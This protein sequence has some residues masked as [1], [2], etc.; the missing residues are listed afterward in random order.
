M[1]LMF[2]KTKKICSFLI[3][4]ILCFD[5]ASAQQDHSFKTAYR[6]NTLG[7]KTGVIH[8]D[9]DGTGSLGFQAERMTFNRQ[10]M[11]QS[12]EF[13]Y[14][15]TWQSEEIKP[16]NWS[17]FRLDQRTAFKYDNRGLKTQEKHYQGVYLK[18][19]TDYSYDVL[20]RMECE[21]RR[22]N[23]GVTASACDAT[24]SNDYGYDR[25]TRYT[26]DNKDRVVLEQRAYDTPLQQNYKSYTYQSGGLESVTDA[27]GNYTYYELDNNYRLFRTYFPSKTNV[28]GYS[29][30]DYEQYL[31]DNNGN[32]KQ[33]RKRDGRLISKQYDNLNRVIK[34]DIPSSTSLDV[35]YGYDNRDLQTYARFGSNT[36]QGITTEYDGFGNISK[37]TNNT[38]GKTRIIHKTYDKNS[39]ISTLKYPDGKLF[40]FDFNARDRLTHIKEGT[41]T[42]VYTHQYNHVNRLDIVR[43]GSGGATT[44]FDFN[45]LYRLSKL[46]T[47]FSGTTYDNQTDFTYTPHHQIETITRSNQ[48]FLHTGE[49]G[50]EGIYKV[51]G[52]NQ[53]Y[54]VKGNVI[55]YDDNGNLTSHENINYFYDVENRLTRITGS[56]SATLKYDPMGKLIQFTA[57]STTRFFAYDGDA[58]IAEYDSS[59]NLVRRHVHLPEVDSPVITYNGNSVSSSLRRFLHRNHQGS[60]IAES[61]QG[62]SLTQLNTYDEFGVPSEDNAG[63]FGYT[64]QVALES[65]GLYYYKARI[66]HP[67]LGRFL[68]TDPVG[69]EDQMN[70][71]AYVGN[72]PINMADPTGK[73]TT[74]VGAAAGCAL[75]GPACPVGA[76]IGAVVGTAVGVGAVIVYNEMSDDAP[77]TPDPESG[78]EPDPADKSGEL[79]R[80]G[81]NLQKHGSRSG[82]AFPPA[83]GNA[84]SKNKQGQEVLEGIVNDPDATSTE[85]NR[86]GGTDVTSSDG[87]GARFDKD[88][89]F[90]GFLEPKR[91]K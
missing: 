48:K 23:L 61:N 91:D 2:R 33:L 62:G 90:R 31:Y 15:T 34:K 56:I 63:R 80:S 1:Q 5:A 44:D 17:S 12:I 86:F 67:K 39:N 41:S 20:G 19:Q 55:S 21:A 11:L 60:I 79:T 25:V 42:S 37:N 81:R 69:Y 54:N 16:E 27:N 85:G 82:S 53:Y 77:A 87:R 45:D 58:L 73:T 70:L 49:K 38:L 47:N 83:T 10:G 24:S 71:Y 74:A 7:Q 78:N 28:G 13:G 40:S 50:I 43:R 46:K 35:Y 22:A 52:L 84:E 57:G 51:N 18:A 8:S 9:P 72:D 66:Y 68:K 29:S 64:G 59:N 88:G 36:G 26:Y 65:T 32:L 76:A 89:K 30:A 6:Y 3:L 14:L 4:L 75:T